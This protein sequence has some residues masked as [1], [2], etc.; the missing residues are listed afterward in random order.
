[1]QAAYLRQVEALDPSPPGDLSSVK[2][3]G[4][5]VCAGDGGLFQ[6]SAPGD[7]SVDDLRRCDAKG[8]T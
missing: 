6:Q 4:L 1:M 5:L 8:L 2:H 3:N 7:L